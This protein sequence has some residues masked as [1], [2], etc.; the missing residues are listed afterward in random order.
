MPNA[1]INDFRIHYE[2]AGQ[3]PLVVLLHGIGSNARSWAHQLQ[4][5]AVEYDVVAWDMRG[6]GSSS[7]PLEPYAMADIASDLAG[8]LQHLGFDKAHIGGLSMGGVIAQEF[9]GLYPE[10]VRSLILADTNA[11]QKRLGEDERQARLAQ[12]LSGAAEPTGLARVRTPSLLSPDASPEVVAE[13]ESIMA[14]IHPE[15]YRLAARAF[16]ETDQSDL[17][18][19][20]EVPAL[21]IWGE[22]DT[23]VTREEADYLVE[24]IK[25]ARLEVIPK[26]G[27]L[28]NLE[29][30]EAF[31]AALLRF[32]AT[33]PA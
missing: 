11:G 9:Y 2:R 28:S 19:R 14:E 18:P 33:V 7:D 3:G 5:L 13:A 15:G 22:C 31:N 32:L 16:A 1:T 17:L 29:N 21:V 20:I 24:N 30:I 12:R 27:H 4:A 10:R 23:V 26:A 25:G 8:L 6:Y